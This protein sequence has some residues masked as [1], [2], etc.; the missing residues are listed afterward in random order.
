MRRKIVSCTT[1]TRI[2]MFR[3]SFISAH[4]VLSVDDDVVDYGVGQINGVLFSRRRS[5][6]ASH[7]V[8]LCYF[9]DERELG[10]RDVSMGESRSLFSDDR[11]HLFSDVG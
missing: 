6:M 5:K 2:G 4:R 11:E 7:E 1:A 9:E 10:V 3:I 8:G